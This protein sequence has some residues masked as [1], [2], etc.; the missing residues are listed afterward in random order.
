MGLEYKKR[1]FLARSFLS[2]TYT[3]KKNKEDHIEVKVKGNAK[4]GQFSNESKTNQ[5]SRYIRK[6]TE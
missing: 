5:S 2:C 6:N 1:C 3:A 4:D